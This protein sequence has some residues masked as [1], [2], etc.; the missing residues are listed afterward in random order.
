MLTICAI[1]LFFISCENNI[2]YKSSI[3]YESGWHKDSTA[4][5]EV[6]FADTAQV[7]DFILTFSHRD[8]YRFCN[9]WLFTSVENFEYQ[10]LHKDTLELIMSYPDGRWFG[11]KKGENLEISTYFKHAVKMAH[12]GKYKFEFQQGM[13]VDNLEQINKVYFK[14]ISR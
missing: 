10:T 2:I 13:R 7:M 6:I 14:I 1:S 9:L 11:K 8:E 4:V 12:P 5:F 3:T